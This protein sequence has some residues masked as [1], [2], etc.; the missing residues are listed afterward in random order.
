[1]EVAGEGFCERGGG[2]LGGFE[3]GRVAQVAEGLGGD[4]ADGG[5]E[6]GL[7]FGAI[8]WERQAGGFEQVEEIGG[9]RGAGE[10]DGVGPGGG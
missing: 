6:D 3:V 9:G 8:G 1:M 5:A 10:G 7:A 2:G 4:R